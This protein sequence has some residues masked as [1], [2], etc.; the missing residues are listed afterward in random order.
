MLRSIG[1]Q[2]LPRLHPHRHLY[3]APR[4]SRL[5]RSICDPPNIPVSLT[6]MIRPSHRRHRDHNRGSYND[7]W[8]LFKNVVHQLETKYVPMKKVNYSN[9]EPM[10]LSH[11]VLKS[12]K[13]QHKVFRKYKDPTHPAC[14]NANLQASKAVHQ[15]RR[16]FAYKH[17]SK[18]KDDK[19][20]SL[21]IPDVG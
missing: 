2:P 3:T 7:C 1:N 19:N 6:P 11:K 12:V 10:W 21:F 15:S 16:A 17:V 5:R 4:F 9:G 20:P 13:H 14:K 8:G 18:L